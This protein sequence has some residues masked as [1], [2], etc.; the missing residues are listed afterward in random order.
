[1]TGLV[2]KLKPHEKVL[3]NGVV[4]QNGDRAAKLRIRTQNVSILR[5][6]D[7]LQPEE[8]NTPLK[9][10]YYVAQLALAGEADEDEARS[11]I[12][13]GLDQVAPIFRGEARE[14]ID[15]ARQGIDEGKFFVVMRAM[16]SLFAMEAALLNPASL[17]EARPDEDAAVE[18]ALA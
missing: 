4:V 18:E 2:L 12:T 13:Q 9:R 3:L 11:Q 6:R 17:L 5:T 8:A 14:Q 7:A 15:R 10:I 16:K 1:M